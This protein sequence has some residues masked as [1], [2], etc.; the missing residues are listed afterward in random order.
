[1]KL[2]KLE[3]HNIASIEDAVID[4]EASPLAESNV[5]LIT[6]ETGSGKST[7]LDAICLALYATTPRMNNTEM[8]GK[9]QEN[10]VDEMDITDT[11]QLMRKNTNEAYVRLSFLGSDGNEY[12]AEW[13]VF[14]KTKKL[15]RTWLLKNL[16]RPEASPQEGNGKGSAKDNEIKQAIQ[17]AVGLTFDQFCRTTMLAQGEFTRFLKSSNKEKAAILEKITNTEQYARIGAKVFDLTHRKYEK[18]MNDVDPAKKE[19]QPLPAE[20]RKELEE[21]IKAIVE[22]SKSLNAQLEAEQNKETWL[23][24]EQT[25]LANQK[26]AQDKLLHA[27]AGM[28][29]SDFKAK[30]QNVT[31]W[32]ST[33]EARKYLTAIKAANETI[34]LENQNIQRLQASYIR[35]LNG[36][37]FIHQK[38]NSV[39]AD[40][41]KI[42]EEIN[43]E[44]GQPASLEELDRQKD[45]ALTLIGNIDTAKAHVKNYF[46]K[47]RERGTEQSRLD[48]LKK[49]IE[50]QSKQYE[51]LKPKV[52][53]ANADFKERDAQYERLNLAVDTLAQKLRE[54]LKLG[55][56]C[57]I[58][59][60]QV[61]SL[62][63]VPHEQELRDIVKEAQKKR[64]EAKKNY[65]DL[66][67]QQNAC[68]IWLNQNIPTYDKDLKAFNEDKSLDKAKNDALISLD[69]CN[70]KQLDEHTDEVLEQAKINANEQKAIIDDKIKRTKYRDGLQRTLDNL[71]K[72]QESIEPIVKQMC[73]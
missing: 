73:P 27:K 11:M 13:S 63:A 25:L 24:T 60:Q 67:R 12:N 42:E 22:Q 14:R 68:V 16:T 21:R 64:D 33:E 30:Q 51:D 48:E 45:A 20:K 47:K 4:F 17:A 8:D 71:K 1:M 54:K 38:I 58:C 37:E 15:N 57:P 19:Q 50:E 3:I 61:Q 46:D 29:T 59:G 32:D 69:K 34:Q 39:S 56:R 49:K 28:E 6:G 62:D 31:D 52:D 53:A 43:A 9:W 40:I 70:I 23:S 44:G 65:D 18:E 35:M 7:I 26:D 41:Q 72:D 2:R 5:V 55:K 10:D 36:Q 66:L